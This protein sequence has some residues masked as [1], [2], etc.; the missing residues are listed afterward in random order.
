MAA[1]EQKSGEETLW[2]SMALSDG[3]TETGPMGMLKQLQ[4]SLQEQFDGSGEGLAAASVKE[5]IVLPEEYDARSIGRSPVIKSQGSFGTCWAITVTSAL[6]AALMPEEHLVFSADHLSLQN[7]FHITQNEGGDYTMA[8]AYLSS[9]A[10]PV[11]ETDDPYGDG[12]SPEGLETQVHV[13]EMQLLEGM[14]RQK[15]KQMIY[16]YGPVQTSLYMDR[17]T[18]SA[19]K[20]YYNAQ[21]YAYCYPDRDTPNHDILILGWDDNY[22]KE[23]F[24]VQ[25]ETDGA[26]ICQN[27]WGDSF[28]DSGIFYVSYQDANIAQG[29]VAYT[30]V[31]RADNY[32][33]IYQT[34]VCGWQGQQGYETES[35]YFANVYTAR[36]EE[37]LEA[38][39]FY[40]T[41]FHSEY[42]IYVVE[43]FKD[44]E[45][46]QNKVFAGSGRIENSGYF[47]IPLAL[48]PEL[49]EGERFAVVVK[50]TTEGA[51][52]P[53]AVELSK[54]EYT[55]TVTLDGK[56]GYLSLY[57]DS[58]EYTEGKFQTNVC[59]KAYTSSTRRDG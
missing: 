9:W 36:G 2:S 47:T 56:E 41:D 24:K 45:S 13:Q 49:T 59:L 37:R 17:K 50:I 22:P 33:Q 3:E 39:G 35:C 4:N 55:D 6:E 10:G 42:E 28:G 7:G 27:T 12:Y 38:V 18:T 11:L 8:M 34:D 32:D 44:T 30:N 19:A 26:Y 1:E 54:D 40:T 48:T 14:S 43:D 20:E 23:N 15:I 16:E 31:E 58:W 51:T 57:G 29:G 52:K 46:F 25:P 21:A 5:L 53:V